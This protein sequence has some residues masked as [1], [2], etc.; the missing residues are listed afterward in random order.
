MFDSFSIWDFYICLAA[1][2]LLISAGN[3]LNRFPQW[4][5]FRETR[6]ESL[7]VLHTQLLPPALHFDPPSPSSY[8]EVESR[9]K[10]LSVQ[11]TFNLRCSL[12]V[13]VCQKERFLAW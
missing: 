13:F 8:V 1:A 9:L 3:C 2:R 12:L 10:S 5:S 6:R 7:A 4:M 11:R